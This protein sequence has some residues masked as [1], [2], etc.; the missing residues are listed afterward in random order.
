M[1]AFFIMTRSV[2]LNIF[3]TGLDDTVQKP[4]F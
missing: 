4:S 2:D 1:E 3:K